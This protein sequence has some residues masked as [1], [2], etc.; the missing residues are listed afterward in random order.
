MNFRLQ[1]RA[2]WLRIVD[3]V[4]T[5]SWSRDGRGLVYRV[6]IEELKP[7]RRTLQNARYWALLTAI[8]QQAPPHMGG[9]H[10]VPEVW[11]EYV[12][13]RFAGMEAGP[14]G[15]GVRKRTRTMRVGEFSSLMEEIE[16]WAR[17]T[18]EGFRFDYEEVAA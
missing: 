6:S 10:H 17:D 7:T 4:R 16:V 13:R 14:W 2:D 3:Y 8:S 12:V 1:T 11:H 9:E 5:I 15:E 18:F